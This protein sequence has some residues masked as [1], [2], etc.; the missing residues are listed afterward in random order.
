MSSGEPELGAAKA[1]HAAQQT[2][3]GACHERCGRC[4]TPP[5][6]RVGLGAISQR[7]QTSLP[8]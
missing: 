6:W 2:D 3:G 8:R 5:N 7:L 1:D 4:P